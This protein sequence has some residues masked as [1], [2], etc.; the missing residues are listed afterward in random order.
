MG[1]GW[2]LYQTIVIDHDLR[3]VA[4]AIGICVLGCLTALAIAQQARKT[5]AMPVRRGWLLL[6]GAITGLTIWTTHFTAMVGYRTDLAIRFD[7]VWA[8]ASVL[9]SIAAAMAAWVCGFLARPRGMLCGAMLGV[10]IAGAHFIDM[11]ALRVAGAA[12][13]HSSAAFAAVVLGV[14]AATLAG[15]LFARSKGPALDWPAAMALA[16]AILSLHFMDMSGVVIMPGALPLDP[17]LSVTAE[18]MGTLVVGAFLSLLAA[19]IVYCWQSVRAAGRIV[20]EQARLIETLETLRKA[21]DHHRASVELSHQIRWV[22]DASGGIIEIAPLWGE[23][24]GAPPE[25]ALGDGWTDVVHPDDRVR[26][27]DVWDKVLRLGDGKLAD[28]RCRLR[29]ADGSYR[30]FRVRAQPRCDEA[31]AVVAW[32]GTL[33]DIDEQVVA[34]TA[35]RESEERFRIASR[36]ANEVVWDWSFAEGCSRWAGAHMDVLGYPELA[37]TTNLD[38]WL[39]RI[40]PTD[41]RRVL[42]NQAAAFADGAENWVEEYRFRT[43]WG[44]WIDVR[45][46]CVIVRDAAG[47]P[48]RLVGSMLDITAQKKAQNELKRAAY[49]DPLTGLPNRALYRMRVE[50][51]IDAAGSAGRF[52]ALVVLDLNSFKELNDTLGHAAGDKVL[53]AVARRLSSSVPDSATVARLGG[54]EFAIIFPDLPSARDFHGLVGNL[55]VGL[56]DPVAVDEMRTPIA[57]CAGIALWPR[58]AADPGGLLIAADLALY[59]AKAEPP[60]TMLEFSPSMREASERRSSELA[61]ARQALADDGIVPFYQPK[62][63]LRTGQIT[64][65]EALLRISGADGEVLFPSQ[66]EAA[67]TDAELTVRLTDRMLSRVFADMAAWRSAGVDPGRIA[68]NVSPG[69]FRQQRLV[70]RLRYH[71]RE[72]GQDLAEIDIEVTEN[73]L[74]GQLGLEVSRMIDELKALGMQVALDDFGTGYASLTHLQRFPIDVIK[75]DKSFIDLIDQQQPHTTVVIDAVL[76]MARRL[77]LA[78]VAEGL[79]SA[80]QAHYLRARGCTT[81][82]GFFFSTPVAAADVPPILAAQPFEHWEF[83]CAPPPVAPLAS[84]DSPPPERRTSLRT[85][86]VPPISPPC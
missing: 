25:T 83:A 74:I 38:W 2:N 50:Q 55:S 43:A 51:A 1:P 44:T 48:V 29:L 59:A 7:L 31:G 32:Y 8:L 65:W 77:G 81:G 42:A 27:L 86:P 45:S 57:F 3:L 13:H 24:V 22:A 35:L 73:V 61:A 18:H 49:H 54:D 56:A 9:L 78:T 15:H 30:W 85:Q 70:E 68:V 14:A 82:Q 17:S 21:Q 66:I 12:H 47:E 4:L 63:D 69:D 36:A 52:V 10:S 33:E 19:A 72:H 67:F 6:A 16:G 40:E 62:V 11:H 64:G 58:D 28:I 20:E 75:I 37:G 79:E 53:E 23:L 80:E 39:R 5:Q 26:V 46:R 76:Q 41:T 71:A 84:V 34:E 60:G